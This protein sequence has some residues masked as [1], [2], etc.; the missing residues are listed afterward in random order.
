MSAWGAQSDSRMPSFTDPALKGRLHPH[1]PL[2]S[3][4]NW[5]PVPRIDRTD[6]RTAR[7]INRGEER[8]ISVGV[9]TSC[10]C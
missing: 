5:K 8:G 1:T 10:V 7:G 2:A 9:L 6:Q 3:Q 4:G